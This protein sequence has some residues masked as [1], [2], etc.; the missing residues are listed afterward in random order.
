M[1]FVDT[2]HLV[3]AH[4]H[5]DEPVLIFKHSTQCPISAYAKHEVEEFLTQTNAPNIAVNVIEQRAVSNYI[6][7][8]TGVVHQSP[9]AIIVH[10]TTVLWSAS[11]KTITTHSLQEAWNSAKNS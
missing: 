6:Q 8:R 10:G 9:Q 5:A 1:N 11:H 2:P 3:D 7:E 4:L